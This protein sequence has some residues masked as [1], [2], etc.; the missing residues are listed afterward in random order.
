MAPVPRPG[1]RAALVS[2]ASAACGSR[3]C[4]EGPRCALEFQGPISGFVAAGRGGFGG[5]E[6]SSLNLMN[7]KAG[8]RSGLGPGRSPGLAALFFSSL[9]M[10]L[11]FGGCAGGVLA[12]CLASSGWVSLGGSLGCLP[13]E[14]SFWPGCPMRFGA[15]EPRALG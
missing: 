8:F 12:E 3:G 6:G 5:Q 9:V 15:W 11:C 7:C 2:I 13:F 10:V 1:K 14:C 4:R